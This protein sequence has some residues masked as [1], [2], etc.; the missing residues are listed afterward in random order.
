MIFQVSSPMGFHFVEARDAASAELAAYR[1]A[2][3]ADPL[4]CKM[5]PQQFRVY[6]QLSGDHYLEERAMNA[7]L[8]RARVGAKP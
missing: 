7:R 1:Q 6:H 3:Y 4:A 2:Q 5:Q 8:E